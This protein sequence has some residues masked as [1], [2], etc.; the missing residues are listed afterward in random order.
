MPVP[1]PTRVHG[2]VAGTPDN[3][4]TFLHDAAAAELLSAEDEV[5]LAQTIELG[6][7]AEAILNGQHRVSAQSPAASATLAELEQ[8]AAEGHA[9][10]VAFVEANLRLVIALARRYRNQLPLADAVQEGCLGLI[11]AIEKFDYR[12]GYKFSTYA[13]WWVRQAIDRALA[14]YTQ[15]VHIPLHVQEQIDQVVSVRRAVEIR[16]G[17]AATL[18]EIAEA[19]DLDVPQ[20]A[21]LLYLSRRHT[22]LD[23][24]LDA[25]GTLT[26]ADLLEDPQPPLETAADAES[27]PDSLERLILDLDERSADIIR[28]RYGLGDGRPAR[29]ADVA[30]Q[31]GITT[32]RVR[33]LERKALAHIKGQIHV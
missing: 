23:A 14:E 32:E 8:L 30:R 18:R 19:A 20:V 31:W 5:R 11:R 9:A 7:L 1:K 2:A 10:M 21:E 27:D 16:L 12:Q 33:Q 28:Q 25:A 29:L 4:E 13:T 26:L 24:P 15:I 6:V 22:S 17:H 3:L